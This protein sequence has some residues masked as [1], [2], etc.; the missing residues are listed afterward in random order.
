MDANDPKTDALDPKTDAKMIPKTLSFLYDQ[1]ARGY[2]AY[3][4]PACVCRSQI[5]V[6]LYRKDSWLVDGNYKPFF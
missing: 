1:G 6:F 4:G 2:A 3:L 5:G